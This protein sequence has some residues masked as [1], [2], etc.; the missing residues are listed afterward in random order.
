MMM[1]LERLRDVNWINAGSFFDTDLVTPL[2]Q[3]A[4]KTVRKDELSEPL[5]S[6]FKGK[7]IYPCATLLPPNSQAIID[8]G[9]DARFTY[10]VII[11]RRVE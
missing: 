7:K 1:H 2:N 5:R 3:A 6:F 11:A 10:R 4:F 8:L 9:M